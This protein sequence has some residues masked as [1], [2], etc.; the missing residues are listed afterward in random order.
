MYVATYTRFDICYALSKASRLRLGEALTRNGQGN[1]V[2]CGTRGF[3]PNLPRRRLHPEWQSED[4]RI[5]GLRLWRRTSKQVGLQQPR[6]QISRPP[7][8]FM[9]LGTA[10]YWKSQLQPVVA[11]STGEAEFRAMWLAISETL[12]CIHFLNELGYGSYSKPLVP[13]F[14]DS[15]VGVAHAKRDSLAWLEG[16]KQYET[17]LSCAY[18]HCRLGNIVP[19]KIDGKDNPADL[20]SKSHKTRS[21]NCGRVR[22]ET[23]KRTQ[24]RRAIRN[25]DETSSHREL[26]RNIDYTGRFH[27]PQDLLAKYG[28]SPRLQ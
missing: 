24:A 14:C 10:T 11:T 13:L 5:H 20:L 8:W 1:Q 4:I 2:P 17:Q 27:L 6:T 23:R 15:N 9:A 22:P 28:F 19:I 18:Q 12:F 7:S 3:D 16:T 21:T 25:M 26:R